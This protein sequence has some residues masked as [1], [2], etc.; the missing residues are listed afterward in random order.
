MVPREPMK[1]HYIIPNQNITNMFI[2]VPNLQS[3]EEIEIF[4]RKMFEIYK[5]FMPQVLNSM[6]MATGQ[7]YR[8]QSG[9][10]P[11]NINNMGSLSSIGSMSNMSGMP[12]MNVGMT[13]FGAM[14]NRNGMG[15][16]TTINPMYQQK[17]NDFY[18]PGSSYQS[19]YFYDN[20]MSNAFPPQQPHP[21]SRNDKNPGNDFRPVS[22]SQNH[23]PSMGFSFYNERQQGEEYRGGLKEMNLPYSQTKLPVDE[24]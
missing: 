1:A 19:R 12:P 10:P 11:Y 6:H 14:N 24:I 3:I 23:L 22:S 17:P 5:N 2:D 9:Y 7:Y 8:P 16:I 18:D 21:M 20:K 13:D 4:Q 15:P